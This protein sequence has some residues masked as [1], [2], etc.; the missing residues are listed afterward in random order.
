MKIP[1]GLGA[2]SSFGFLYVKDKRVSLAL[3]VT[4]RPSFDVRVRASSSLNQSMA[5][6]AAATRSFLQV[7]AT[8]EAVAPPLRVVQI[9]GLLNALFMLLRVATVLHVREGLRIL[10]TRL[11]GVTSDCD[12]GRRARG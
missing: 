8:E 3:D 9:E 1:S 4:P 12:G 7:A 2:A 11:D 6:A 5:T 10:K